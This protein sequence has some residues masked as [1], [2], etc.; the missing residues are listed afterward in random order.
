[1]PVSPRQVFVLQLYRVLITEDAGIFLVPCSTWL[2]ELLTLNPG[3]RRRYLS[4]LKRLSTSKGFTTLVFRRFE[5]RQVVGSYKHE[6]VDGK[7]ISHRHG[8]R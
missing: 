3:T 5:P 8:H 6:N 4:G 1:M 7:T 2:Y